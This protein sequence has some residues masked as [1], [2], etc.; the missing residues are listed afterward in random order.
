MP[1]GSP[2]SSGHPPSPSTTEV[3]VY[4]AA[5]TPRPVGTWCAADP[6]K[7]RRCLPRLP[8]QKARKQIPSTC[9][10]PR[11]VVLFPLV[12]RTISPSERR[13]EAEAEDPRRL[14]P[15]RVTEVRILLAGEEVGPVGVLDVVDGPVWF[16]RSP[17][18]GKHVG[19]G[20]AL[21]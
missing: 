10:Y 16:D 18:H 17:Q 9:G 8:R 13:P 5:K 20:V 11:C 1:I 6:C 3:G 2:L 4:F 21:V 19:V 15:R 7:R 12:G 14:I